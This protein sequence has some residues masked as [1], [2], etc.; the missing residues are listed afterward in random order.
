MFRCGRAGTGCERELNNSGVPD[1][2]FPRML[3]WD[4]YFDRI[5]SLHL[6]FKTA[7]RAFDGFKESE[8]AM[9]RYAESE[10]EDVRKLVAEGAQRE[11]IDPQSTWP[12]DKEAAA[13]YLD[14]TKE[15]ALET[16]KNLGER[17][18]QYEFILRVAMFEGFMKDMHRAIL[19]S[20]PVL[21]RPDR[22]IP[23]GKLISK[24]FDS[25]LQ[26]EIEREIQILDRKSV[27]E[28]ADYFLKRL[29]ISWF[30]GSIV[31]MLDAVVR[32]RNELLHE[33][34]DR[35]LTYGEVLF[36]ELTTVSVPI[37]TL[38]QSALLYPGTCSLPMGMTEDDAKKFL[39]GTGTSK[40]SPGDLPATER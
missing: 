40:A 4:S 6:Q 11:N 16:L 28:K 19:S 27:A 31:P 34:Q 32:A 26:E 18:Q 1:I 8:Q 36:M 25:V 20:R 23:F 14:G 33:N 21:L 17:L 15:R 29:G 13:K 9:R 7:L 22:Q 30:E 24:G 3:T 37:A 39:Q 5:V 10:L 38:A 35:R 12:Y 2:P